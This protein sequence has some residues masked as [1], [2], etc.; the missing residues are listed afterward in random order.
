[1]SS[2]ASAPSAARASWI[3]RVSA[4]FAAA[5]IIM[6]VF[7]L[8]GCGSHGDDL[9]QQRDEVD[10][11]ED[12]SD[13]ASVEAFPS[14]ERAEPVDYSGITDGGEPLGSSSFQSSVTV[15][16]FWYA[17][18]PPCQAEAPDLAAAHQEFAGDGVEFIG[19]NAH[20]DEVESLQF[21]DRFDIEYPSFLDAE[22]NRSIQRAV[23]D[24][25]PLNAVPTTR[26][27]TPWER[28]QRHEHSG[29]GH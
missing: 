12:I 19:V 15:M 8:S 4:P 23:V 3:R 21:A 5:S 26:S 2:F 29:S 1:M 7:A 9:A 20:D 27:S 11:R 25:V 6:A 22:G 16:N 28:G 17:A 14:E 18:C 13:G 10:D 24:F